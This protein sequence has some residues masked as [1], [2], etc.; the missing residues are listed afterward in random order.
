MK[1]CGFSRRE[2]QPD[3]SLR[4]KIRRIYGMLR[5]KSMPYD[6]R[7]VSASYKRAQQSVR[8]GLDSETTRFHLKPSY[9]HRD[10]SSR[11]FSSINLTFP[12]FTTIR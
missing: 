1:R 6:G 8:A 11:D 12:F 5:H 7:S 2:Y 10:K 4:R 3:E 9:T